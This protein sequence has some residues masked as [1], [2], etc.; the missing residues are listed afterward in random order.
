VIFCALQKPKTLDEAVDKLVSLKL[1][2]VRQ[3]LTA[4]YAAKATALAARLEHLEQRLQQQAAQAAA[5]PPP[6]SASS[7]GGKGAA[8]SSRV[9]SAGSRV[10]SAKPAA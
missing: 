9:A 8:V 5:A 7:H 4:E 2:D 3:G 6:A 1:E 10:A